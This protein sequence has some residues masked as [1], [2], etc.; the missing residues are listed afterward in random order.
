MENPYA[1]PNSV[2]Y[3]PG[4]VSWRQFLAAT[5]ISLLVAGLLAYLLALLFQAGLYFIFWTPSFAALLLSGM[6]FWSI[7]VGHCRSRLLAAVIGVLGTILLY[8]GQYHFDMV[9]RVGPETIHRLDLLPRYVAWRKSVEKQNVQQDAARAAAPP[10][11]HEIVTNWIYAGLELGIV[12]FVGV[13]FALAAASRPYC[14][15]CRKWMRRDAI[16]LP[17]DAA[18]SLVQAVQKDCLGDLLGL[19]SVNLHS[20]RQY[21]AVTVAW[22]PPSGGGASRCP[23]FLSIKSVSFGGGIGQLNQIDLAIGRT[24]LGMH[25]LTQRQIAELQAR[26]PEMSK[27]AIGSERMSS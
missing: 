4:K 22:C 16:F 27:T 3:N 6:I 24:G 23:G 2:E 13:G 19:G 26:F 17:A 25:P 10:L 15:R 21:T 1:S 20:S 12:A 8:F 9:M 14:S 5:G 7:R 18:P 11:P